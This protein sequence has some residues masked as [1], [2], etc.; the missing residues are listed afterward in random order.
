MFMSRTYSGR[1][2][3]TGIGPPGEI[4][5][6]QNMAGNLLPAPSPARDF[7]RKPPPPTGGFA[8]VSLVEE[9]PQGGSF[10]LFETLL[11]HESAALNGKSPSKIVEPKQL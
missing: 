9:T 2:F 3:T 1:E 5:C 4:V 11:R 7:P 10:A 8:Q 6:M